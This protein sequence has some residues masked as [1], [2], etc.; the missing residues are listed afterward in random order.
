M[1]ARAT[2]H[3]SREITGRTVL[4]CFMGF[5]GVVAAVNAF[6]I[7]AAVT[8]FAGT[9]TASAYRAGLAYKEEEAAAAAQAALNWQV[10]GRIARNTAG[11]AVLT[12]QIKDNNGVP[13]RGIAVD[14]RLVHPASARLDQAVPLTR[15]ADGSFRGS[16]EIAAGQWTLSLD[17]ERDGERVYRTKSRVMLK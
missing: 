9:E 1:N 16:A 10:E 17:I 15:M 8:T 14:A 13:V 2:P 6:M 3:K 11:D 5:F 7:R 12:V 4:I